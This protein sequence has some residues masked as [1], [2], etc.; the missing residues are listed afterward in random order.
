MKYYLWLFLLSIFLL[1]AEENGMV[2]NENNSSKIENNKIIVDLDKELTNSTRGKNDNSVI[3]GSLYVNDNDE[4]SF[5]GEILLEKSPVTVSFGDN[6]EV[7]FTS[8]T[9]TVKT[10]ELKNNM[11]IIMKDKNGTIFVNQVVRKF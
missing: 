5:K 7:S 8:N 9:F 4:V 11:H 10:M 6:D 1:N 2:S 3:E